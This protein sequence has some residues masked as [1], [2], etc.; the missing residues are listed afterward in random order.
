MIKRVNAVILTFNNGDM[1]RDLLKNLGNQTFPL[2]K[3]IVVDN[4]T[5]DGTDRMISGMFPDIDYIRLQKNT[6]SAGY[7]RCFEEGLRGAD[8]IWAL[9]DDVLPSVDALEKLL[10]GYE[11]MS[12]DHPLGNVRSVGSDFPGA[13]PSLL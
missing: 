7:A 3:I 4:A 1:L 12:K 9:D 13:E 2:A 10:A 11:R 6:G 8:A 5:I